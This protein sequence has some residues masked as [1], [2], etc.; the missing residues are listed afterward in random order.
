MGLCLEICSLDGEGD[1]FRRSITFSEWNVRV[2]PL[3]LLD[4]VVM[5]LLP[6]R[7]ELFATFITTSVGIDCPVCEPRL[8]CCRLDISTVGASCISYKYYELDVKLI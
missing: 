1:T 5:A 6:S 4:P 8:D 2:V 7:C 3:L